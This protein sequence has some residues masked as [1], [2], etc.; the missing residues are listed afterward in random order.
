MSGNEHSRRPAICQARR[1]K[2]EAAMS[3]YVA[4][5]VCLRGSG[6]VSGVYIYRFS[7]RVRRLGAVPLLIAVSGRFMDVARLYI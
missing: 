3:C 2:L 6:G 5:F 4:S 1:D 7:E